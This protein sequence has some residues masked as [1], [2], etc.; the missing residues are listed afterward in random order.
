VVENA[1][2]AMDENSIPPENRSEENALPF[3]ILDFVCNSI[4]FQASTA[5]MIHAI[6]VTSGRVLLTAHQK[7]HATCVGLI[8]KAQKDFVKHKQNEGIE[9][10]RIWSN[11]AI[12]NA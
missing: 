12:S 7:A 9:C 10:Y 5:I 4:L 2:H 6:G 3:M 8:L 1:M 11:T